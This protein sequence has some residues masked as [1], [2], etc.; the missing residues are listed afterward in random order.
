[1]LNSPV[2][3][4]EFH[5]NVQNNSRCWILKAVYLSSVQFW[6]VTNLNRPKYQFAVNSYKA[7]YIYCKARVHCNVNYKPSVQWRAI[8]SWMTKKTNLHQLQN[9]I[10]LC[11]ICYILF[12]KK[13]FKSTDVSI[14]FVILSADNAFQVCMIYLGWNFNFGNSALDWI[15]A[16]L[17]WRGNAA[18]RMGP[19]PAYIM[20]AVHHEMGICSSQ[21]IVS[22]CRDSA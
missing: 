15:Q 9:I 3:P 21:L 10:S 6:L 5:F 7:S 22:R 4:V 17:E 13:N 16:L 20:G 2:R 19:S 1:M 11:C 14:S 8:F 12:S 18:G